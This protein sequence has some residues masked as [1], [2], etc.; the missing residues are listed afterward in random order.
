[1]NFLKFFR[2]KKHKTLKELADDA[3][4]GTSS[5]HR[6]EEG[7][8]PDLETARKIALALDTTIEEIWPPRHR[9]E[10]KK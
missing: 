10:A 1:M 2:Q 3:L 5:I 4:K 7:Y 8:M 6:Y 9:K